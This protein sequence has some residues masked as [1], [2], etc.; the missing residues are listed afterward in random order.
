MADER[1]RTFYHQGV[2]TPPETQ[3]SAQSPEG[4]FDAPAGRFAQSV[5]DSMP[6]AVGMLR[7]MAMPS[8]APGAGA[9]GAD[10]RLGTLGVNETRAL[11]A[12]T[13]ARAGQTMSPEELYEL[14]RLMEGLQ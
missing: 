2:E 3:A 4:F 1:G 14:D 12:R 13:R 8:P 11:Y 6:N 10:A 5:L 9:G 7:Q